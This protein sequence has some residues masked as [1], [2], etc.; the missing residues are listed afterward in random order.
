[1]SSIPNVSANVSMPAMPSYAP[2]YMPGWNG[3]CYGN[4][5]FGERI[6]DGAG[7]AIG[8]GLVGGFGGCGN[9]WG[10][11]DR[12]CG[13]ERRDHWNEEKEILK[14]AFVGQLQEQ[15]NSDI[16]DKAVNVFGVQQANEKNA[17]ENKADI[18]T[19]IASGTSANMVAFT[20]AAGDRYEKAAEIKAALAAGFADARVERIENAAAIAAQVAAFKCD[21]DAKMASIACE[22]EANRVAIIN[23]ITDVSYTEALSAAATTIA[24]LNQQILINK[25]NRPRSRNSSPCHGH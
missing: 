25:L 8:A 13:Y 24:S 21:A 2:A 14:Q 16:V 4:G 18:L 17:S 6:G 7:L 20:Q 22:A 5:G 19:K 15:T 23:K 3:G 12:D 11:R 9:G 10:G 1:M